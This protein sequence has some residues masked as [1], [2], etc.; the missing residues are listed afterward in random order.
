MRT[1]GHGR[2]DL[3]LELEADVSTAMVFSSDSLGFGYKRVLELDYN[4]HTSN[5]NDIGNRVVISAIIITTT[6]T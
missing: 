3:N 4:N 6:T 2:R 5:I 1:K